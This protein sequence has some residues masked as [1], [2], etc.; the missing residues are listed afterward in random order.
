MKNTAL[1]ED[2]KSIYYD[3]QSVIE[4]KKLAKDH[5]FLSKMAQDIRKLYDDAVIAKKNPQLLELAELVEFILTT[6]IGAP[7]VAESTLLQAALSY[8]ASAHQSSDLSMLMQSFTKHE[9]KMNNTTAK[10]FSS[11]Q[12]KLENI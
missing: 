6:P 3:W 11:I 12:D 9:T 5:D 1:G 7:F 10:I 8:D 2:L 4:N